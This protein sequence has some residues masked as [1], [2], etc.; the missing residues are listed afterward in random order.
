MSASVP[1]PQEQRRRPR[2]LAI[3]G[4]KGGVGKSAITVNLAVAMARKGKRCVLVD[5]DLGGA[6]LHTLVGL[7]SPRTSLADLFTR[8]VKSLQEILLPTGIPRLE[9]ISGARSLLDMA[10]P[11]HALKQK[12]IR[13]LFTLDADVVLI[14]L[15]A[16]ATFNVIDFFL[17]ADDPLAVVV[18]TPTSVENAYHFLKAA[19]YRRLKWA[20]A[21]AGAGPWVDLAL[22][23]K[24]MR[25]IRSPRELIRH[26]LSEDPE[27]GRKVAGAMARLRP[28]LIVNQIRRDEELQ[29]GQQMAS[30]CLDFFGIEMEFLG[31]IR[32]DDRV[33]FSVQMKRPALEAYPFC[34]F[35]LAIEGLAQRL[36]ASAQAGGAH[37]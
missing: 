36:L 3:G 6:N 27:A 29:L 28:K 2:I 30:A 11:K 24:V 25:G 13:Q 37:E 31:G 20:I 14:D 12:I 34:P 18:P 19:F 16:G 22:E 8:D 7:P 4:G 17:A 26:L 10:N 32:N 1:E 33:V 15:S 9:L 35:S 21:E 23:E 5:A